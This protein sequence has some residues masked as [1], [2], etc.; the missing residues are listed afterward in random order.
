VTKDNT[1][2][3]KFLAIKTFISDGLST[4][5]TLKRI[6]TEILKQ[7]GITNNHHKVD[8]EHLDYLHQITPGYVK[9]QLL[10]MFKQGRQ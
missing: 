10:N 2:K 5:I 3:K 4:L 7:L 1:K 9:D 6:Q 8:E